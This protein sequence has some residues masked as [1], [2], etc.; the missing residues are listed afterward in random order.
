MKPVKGAA[1]YAVQFTLKSRNSK[2]GAMPVSTTS[3]ITCPDSCPLKA[4]G[5][6]AE[7]GRVAM[8]WNALSETVPG[9]KFRAGRNNMQSL[10]W[11]Q[12]AHTV[13]ALPESTLWRHN[14]AG[15][16]PGRGDAIDVKALSALV[17]ANRGRRGFTYTHKPVTGPYGA[18]NAQAIAAAN[19]DGFTINLSADTLSEAD[20][21]SALGI[22]P[23][24]VVLPDS[25]QGNADITTPQ[26][27]RVSVC[28]ATYRED[29]SCASCQLCQRQNRKSIVGFPAH[30]AAKRKASAVAQ[31]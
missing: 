13:A 15:D 24:V 10:T 7:S 1:P 28:P 14:Q 4:S 22:A 6:Y 18:R 21:L 23:V 12:F 17:D 5:C 16:L 27:R 8:F 31:G 26:G 19:V 20:A 3:R 2:V 9:A 11:T 29:V 30:G 25:V